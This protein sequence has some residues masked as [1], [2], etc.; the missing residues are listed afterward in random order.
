MVEGKISEV[1]SI[2]NVQLTFDIHSQDGAL[3]CFVL[4]YPIVTFI[5][6]IIQSITQARGTYC[7]QGSKVYFA[8]LWV[9]EFKMFSCLIIYLIPQTA[10][11][12]FHHITCYGNGKY[13]A[14]S[15]ELEISY[16]R[17]KTNYEARGI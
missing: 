17:S 9:S 14:V 1:V 5:L 13:H 15:W 3:F 11:G 2:L 4:Q 10:H 16:G 12:N 8:H 6:A 7:L